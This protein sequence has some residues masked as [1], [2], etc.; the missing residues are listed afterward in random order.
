MASAM[1]TAEMGRMK[2]IIH[3]PWEMSSVCCKDVSSIWASTLAR[4]MGAMG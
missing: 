1:K 4:T 2:K 3:D